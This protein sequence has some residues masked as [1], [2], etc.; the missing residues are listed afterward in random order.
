MKYGQPWITPTGV[1]LQVPAQP[2]TA[3]ELKRWRRWLVRESAAEY[4]RA[5]AAGL[6]VVPHPFHRPGW[7]DPIPR[8]VD[9]VTR[10]LRRPFELQAPDIEAMLTILWP[11]F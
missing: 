1:V 11:G 6:W 7:V 9:R 2:R 8:K 10:A 5:E 3:L 4:D